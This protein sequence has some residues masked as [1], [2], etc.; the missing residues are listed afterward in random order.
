MRE[1]PSDVPAH[2]PRS[3]SPAVARTLTTSAVIDVRHASAFASGHLPRSGQLAPEEFEARR[4]ELPPSDTPILVVATDA[5]EAE[6]AAHAL[7]VLAYRDVS[8]LE[9]PVTALQDQ[10]WVR[11]APERMWR[12][13]S[14]LES[15]IDRIPRGRALDLA[16]GAGREAVYL[17][18]KGFDVEA[19]DRDPDALRRC[20]DLAR[21]HGVRVELVER[22]LETGD[23]GLAEARYPLVACFRYL[24]RPLFP[25]IARA[26]APGGHLVYETYRV[27]QEQF[28]RPKRARFLLEPGELRRSFADLEIL[29]YEEPSPPGGPFTA[30]LH[31]RRR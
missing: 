8:W 7:S 9:A 19:W 1:D 15:T 13:A 22:D 6:R 25:A 21:R 12:P 11:G 26:L 18:L 27:G 5:V 31:A 24:H 2:R 20:A 10:G 4:H 23:P 28:G 14:F 3:V 17:A 30:R 16:C 29:T